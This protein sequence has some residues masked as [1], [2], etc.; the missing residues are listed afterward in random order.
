MS[1]AT[2]ATNRPTG[3]RILQL[4]AWGFAAA[5]LLLATV[6]LALYA[7][8]W[9]FQRRVHH[10][11]DRIAIL[12]SGST[13]RDRTLIL[14]PELKQ[15][16]TG[17]NDFYRCSNNSDCFINATAPPAAWRAMVW[18][19]RK[20]DTAPDD[21]LIGNALPKLI[22]MM[23]VRLQETALCVTFRDG[24]I[25]GWTYELTVSTHDP[26]P[27]GGVQVQLGSVKKIWWIKFPQPHD[28]E[29]DFLVKPLFVNLGDLAAQVL[30]TPRTPQMLQ[31]DA[32]HFDLRC[33]YS[34][35]GCRTA[36]QI[37]AAAKADNERIIEASRARIQ[38]PEPCP[39]VSSVAMRKHRIG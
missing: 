24:R 14:F 21:E 32:Y 30:I 26:R 18:V 7:N 28:E 31:R 36:T 20:L 5:L 39:H 8:L 23:G 10:M 13:T 27:P 25:D 29:P 16:Q 38:S 11:L 12:Q 35:L 1:S 15:V 9:L 33:I 17:S 3:K 19:Y 4:T 34:L 2:Q 22:H 37:V 6:T